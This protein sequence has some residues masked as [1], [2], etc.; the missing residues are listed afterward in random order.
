MAKLKSFRE[1]RV[2]QKLRQLHNEVHELSLTFPKFELYELGSQVRKSSNSAPSQIA[3]GW[4][5][6]HTNVYMEAT[7]RAMGEIRETQHH[8]GA[9]CD[10]GYVSVETFE[11]L[12][13]RYESTS[14]MLERLHQALD[15]WRDTK[16][17]GTEIREQPAAY[18]R[19]ADLDWGMIER[20][21]LESTEIE[22]P[23]SP[24]PPRPTT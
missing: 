16:R 4:G 8:L 5:S 1:L 6:R 18:G 13:E 23:P 22:E 20:L 10:H 11:D 24:S 12:D 17:V 19:L 15:Q 2:Y 21:T 9:A 3:E 14:R 7:N